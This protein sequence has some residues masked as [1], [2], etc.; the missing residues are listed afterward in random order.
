MRALSSAAEVPRL[1]SYDEFPDPFAGFETWMRNRRLLR[2]KTIRNYRT[3]ARRADKWCMVHLNKPLVGATFKDLQA[4][5]D[6]LPPSGASRNNS[7]AGLICY[8]EYLI[9]IGSRK[10]NPAK[11]L[12]R[13]KQRRGTPK[14]FDDERVPLL[15]EEAEK[16]GLMAECAIKLFMYTGKRATEVRLLQWSSWCGD[17]LQVELKG[18]QMQIIPLN[19][20]CQDVLQRWAR[21]C[22]SEK[23]IFPSPKGG[24]FAGKPASESWMWCKVRDVGNRAGIKG[25]RPHRCR[26]THAKKVLRDTGNIMLV[27]EA[28]GHTDLG[29]TLIYVE[30]EKAELRSVQEQMKW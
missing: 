10:K 20:I 12:M 4:F 25:C 6:T 3:A 5:T 11:R 16:D 8:G 19:T 18:G 1:Q 15:L 2:E 21:E 17:H 24:K 14:P 27:K 7:R 23:W 30:M 9:D 26:Y 28:L 22:R 13:S 29:N